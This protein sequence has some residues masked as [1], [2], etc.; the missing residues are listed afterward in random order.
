M[1]TAQKIIKYL[2]IAFAIFLIVTII[3]TIIGTLYA[4]SGVL[5]LKKDTSKSISEI[6]TTNFENSD[7]NELDIELAFTSLKIKTGN[8]FKVETNNNE[9]NYKQSD[10]KLKIEEKN[11]KLFSNHDE[12][13]L[14]LYIPENI[15]IEKVKISTGAGKIDIEKLNTQKLSFE[16]GAGETE[17]QEL[18]V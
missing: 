3:S 6:S 14:I 16:L 7:I 9:I 4:L 15:E 8:E 5:G 12:K 11:N 10:Q 13:E 18:N 1:T 17:I 2:A